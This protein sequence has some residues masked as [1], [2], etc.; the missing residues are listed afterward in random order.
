M[1]CVSAIELHVCVHACMHTR[2]RRPENAMLHCRV[3]GAPATRLR[4]TCVDVCVHQLGWQRRK[5]D[6][7]GGGK[8]CNKRALL[9]VWGWCPRQQERDAGV[10]MVAGAAEAARA[11]V[12][13]TQCDTQLPVRQVCESAER[14]V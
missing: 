7:G 14:C 10:H 4:H 6:V 9:A 11:G 3:C 12:R 13:V 8:R 2:R 1:L 5:H